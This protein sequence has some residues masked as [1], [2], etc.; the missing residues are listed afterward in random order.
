L[1]H[2]FLKDGGE[3]DAVLEGLNRLLVQNQLHR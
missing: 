1:L 3:T 2:Q